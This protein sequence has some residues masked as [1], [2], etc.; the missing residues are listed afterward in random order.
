[1]E[2]GRAKLP[3][4]SYYIIGLLLVRLLVNWRNTE[5]SEIKTLILEIK[6]LIWGD[7][8]TDLRCNW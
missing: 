8:T 6:Y 7:D 4:K 5:G 1:M 3:L 2:M